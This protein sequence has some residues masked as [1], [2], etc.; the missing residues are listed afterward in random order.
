[1]SPIVAAFEKGLAFDISGELFFFLSCAGRN[2]WLDL[3]VVTATHSDGFNGMAVSLYLCFV[4]KIAAVY[5]LQA[6]RQIVISFHLALRFLFQTHWCRC[7]LS[8]FFPLSDV[9]FLF[10]V[11]QFTRRLVI[12]NMIWVKDELG[13]WGLPRSLE[14]CQSWGRHYINIILIYINYINE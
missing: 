2:Q 1:M 5:T 13:W 8:N 6:T 4:E 11:W 7:C 9:E 10:Y 12:F 14:I 3:F